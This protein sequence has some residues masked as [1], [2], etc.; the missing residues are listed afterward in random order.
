[1]PLFLAA[2]LGGLIQATSH[3]VGRVL[4]GLGIGFVAFQGVDTLVSTLR[5]DVLSKLQALAPATVQVL[6]VLQVGT[7]VNIMAS[8]LVARLAIRG[9]SG[10]V[11][12]RMVQK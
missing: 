9:L 1:M 8:A 10:G 12:K 11:I 2:F 6:G 7:C 3:I 5:A 4:I